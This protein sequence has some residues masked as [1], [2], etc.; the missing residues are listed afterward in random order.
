MRRSYSTECVFRWTRMH[1]IIFTV[2]ERRKRPRPASLQPPSAATNDHRNVRSPR[3]RSH[4]TTRL[5]VRKRPKAYLAGQKMLA[6]KP[7][8]HQDAG[9]RSTIISGMAEPAACAYA[10]SSYNRGISNVRGLQGRC[11]GLRRAGTP[12]RGMVIFNRT[13][14][15]PLQPRGGH[16]VQFTVMRCPLRQSEQLGRRTLLGAGVPYQ[17]RNDSRRRKPYRLL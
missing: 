12:R 2:R 11:G 6:G 1:S 3:Q 7:P 9:R 17:S 14:S 15:R 5:S 8:G 16:W 10:T 13:L 4:H